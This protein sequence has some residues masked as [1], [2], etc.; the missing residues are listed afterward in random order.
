MRIDN[1]D[2]QG[3][4]NLHKTIT[5]IKSNPS[6]GA[7][8]I[9][10]G[11]PYIIRGG[12]N[13]AYMSAT[14]L[15][16]SGGFGALN[17]YEIPLPESGSVQDIGP[18]GT[19][20]FVL[21]TNGNLYTVGINAV[22]QLGLGDT[23][24]R[25]VFTLSNTGVTRVFTSPSNGDRNTGG[26]SRLIIQ[27]TDNKVYGCGF[28]LYGNLGLG[29]TTQVISSW[30]ELTWC[31]TSPLSVWNMGN[32]IGGTYCQKSDGTVFATGWNNEGQ[33]GNGST[34]VTV[35]TP[36]NVTNNWL[37]GTFA[38]TG[39]VIQQ[40]VA[41]YGYFDG[42][43][44][45]ES[46]ITM[47]MDN[48][49]TSRIASAGANSQGALGDGTTINRSTPVVPTG[50][51]GRVR[52]IGRVGGGALS[53]V[54]VVK[55]DNTYWNW[56]YN[57]NGQLGRGNNTNQPTPSQVRTDVLQMF[58]AVYAT[59]TTAYQCCSPILETAIAYFITG[60][61]GNGG[62]GVGD[63]TARN[64][65]TQMRFPAGIRLSKAGSMTT[66]NELTSRYAVDTNNNFYAWGEN[67]FNGV[68]D[69]NT[70]DVTV[71]IRVAPPA[72]VR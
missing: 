8:V 27:K 52:Q 51:S 50:F 30:T 25:T 23:T 17:M 39:M 48:G 15:S 54:H 2:L 5:D 3:S 72:L 40:V 61:N 45:N 34:A 36:V 38:A 9:A 4:V 67:A 13:V 64:T 42:N 29:N 35:S 58:D 20:A 53:S 24:D 47:F 59:S 56:G 66:V 62:L 60:F 69:S 19:S 63:A 14:G 16:Y 57:A 65:F 18:Y 43:T 41:S 10:D 46:S 1:A 68:N 28:N 49:T 26:E 33:L 31:G 6:N 22:G 12:N 32:T 44:N 55:T 71:P 7:V 11:V 21:F 37:G 70:V